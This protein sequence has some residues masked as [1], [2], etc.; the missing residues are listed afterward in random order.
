MTMASVSPSHGLK[1]CSPF[2]RTTETTWRLGRT[3]SSYSTENVGKQ[4]HENSVSGEESCYFNRKETDQSTNTASDP[5]GVMLGLTTNLV[6]SSPSSARENT[7]IYTFLTPT[8][9]PNALPSELRLTTWGKKKITP[10]S[11]EE[12]NQQ[13]QPEK[14]KELRLNSD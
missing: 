9:L 5:L 13:K 14:K 2:R 10:P 8:S 4:Q 1:F 11:P 7:Q 3:P 6:T 12:E